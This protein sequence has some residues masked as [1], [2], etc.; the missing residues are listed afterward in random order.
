DSPGAA[1]DEPGPGDAAQGAGEG[2]DP[3]P[4]AEGHAARRDDPEATD[5][6]DR[7]GP[8]TAGQARRARAHPPAGPGHPGRQLPVA[9]LVPRPVRTLAPVGRTHV[10]PPGRGGL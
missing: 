7:L 3:G 5:A 9:V 8:R 6:S 10:V 4:E 2:G 1:V